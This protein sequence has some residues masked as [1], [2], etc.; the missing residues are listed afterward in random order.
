MKT[1]QDNIYLTASSTPM[2]A[3]WQPHPPY[4][5]DSVI[6]LHLWQ[7][8]WLQSIGHDCSTEPPRSCS[9]LL[10]GLL[11]VFQTLGTCHTPWSLLL[12]YVK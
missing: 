1:H 12:V 2:H 7:L 4:L 10:S 8:H 5:H 6:Q 9:L 3:A 11:V